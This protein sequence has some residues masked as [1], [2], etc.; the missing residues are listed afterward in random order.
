MGSAEKRKKLPR[1]G[2]RAEVWG[3]VHVTQSVALAAASRY[4]HRLEGMGLV[5]QA[6]QGLHLLS[7]AVAV[8]NSKSLFACHPVTVGDSPRIDSKH[9]VLCS[10]K[11]SHVPGQSAN[12]TKNSVAQEHT[13]T[14]SHKHVLSSN[15]ERLLS[16]H[17]K[18]PLDDWKDSRKCSSNGRGL[19][20]EGLGNVSCFA[21]S[22]E[23]DGD[24]KENVSHPLALHGG[25][26]VG[27]VWDPNGAP[28]SAPDLRHHGAQD[29]R[30]R[31]MQ[32]Q[33]F[34]ISPQ[35]QKRVTTSCGNY[36]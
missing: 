10:V 24:G 16:N 27:R 29:K 2:I 36:C 12:A 6:G 30:R 14:R 18:G 5:V 7:M 15:L 1:R 21:V 33:K 32:D 20:L 31:Q 23:S 25:R 8:T 11:A 17:L 19:G 3:D 26:I 28:Q 22:D 13:V 4:L 35:R 34:E 9:V